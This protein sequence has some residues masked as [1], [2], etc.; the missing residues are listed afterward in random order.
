MH[1][2]LAIEAEEQ[3]VSLNMLVNQ[4]ITAPTAPRSAAA[5]AALTGDHRQSS[6]QTNGRT[7][8]A[9]PREFREFEKPP[10]RQ[11]G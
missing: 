6:V 5:G 8:R 4:E 1:R 9:T 3:G 10:A 11:F 2:T 7:G